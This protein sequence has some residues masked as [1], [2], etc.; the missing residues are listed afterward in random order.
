MVMAL[1]R[2]TGRRA[3]ELLEV[4]EI[5]WLPFLWDMFLEAVAMMSTADDAKDIG[6]LFPTKSVEV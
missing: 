1:S 3:S 4:P 5:G 6:M 2:R